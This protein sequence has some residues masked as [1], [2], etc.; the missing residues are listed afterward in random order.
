[1]IRMTT[2]SS[3]TEKLRGGGLSGGSGAIGDGDI[4]ATMDHLSVARFSL[5]P[6]PISIPI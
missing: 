1:M 6:D 4:D 3:S 2:M 5:E